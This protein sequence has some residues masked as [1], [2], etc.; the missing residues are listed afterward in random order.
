M[1]FPLNIWL[2]CAGESF[3]TT[4]VNQKR[5]KRKTQKNGYKDKWVSQRLFFWG[6][7][8]ANPIR[9]FPLRRCAWRRGTI[10]GRAS[11]RCYDQW[12]LSDN[13]VSQRW[14]LSPE[15]AGSG[16]RRRRR[17]FLQQGRRNPDFRVHLEARPGPAAARPIRGRED[18]GVH[19]C[20]SMSKCAMQCNNACACVLVLW[21]CFNCRAMV[22]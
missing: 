15:S 16:L 20:Q 5:S 17:G 14:W 1:N 9:G 8:E 11:Q 10:E 22:L 18:R 4:S 13:L 3:Y 6:I 12:G 21:S 7:E 2:C 19:P